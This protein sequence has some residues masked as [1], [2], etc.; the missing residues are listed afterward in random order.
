LQSL[1]LSEADIMDRAGSSHHAGTKSEDEAF[2]NLVLAIAKA[3]AAAV[4]KLL[5]AWP[6]LARHKAASGATRQSPHEYFLAEIEHVLYKG[7]TALHIAAAGYRTEAAAQLLAAGAEVRAKN[8]LGQ[9]PLHYAVLGN[10]GSSRWNPAAQT[11]MIRLL[12]KAGAQPNCID[13]SSVAPLHRAVRTRSSAAVRT[14]LECGADPR[15]TNKS[16]STA[17]VLAKL[18]TGRGGSG[19]PEAKSEQQKILEILRNYGEN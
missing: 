16:G 5:A 19:S 10:P 7:D 1:G 3:D 18:T 17:L 2:N 8:R 4:R 15:Q 13:R 11:E 9:E 12:I 6:A 14:L